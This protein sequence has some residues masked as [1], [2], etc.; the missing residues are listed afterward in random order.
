[1]FDKSTAFVFTVLVISAQGFSVSGAKERRSLG[2]NSKDATGTGIFGADSEPRLLPAPSTDGDDDV[3]YEVPHT[4]NTTEGPS[5]GGRSGTSAAY[6]GG[7]ARSRP[8]P[9]RSRTGRIRDAA[10]ERRGRGG[11]KQLLFPRD[12]LVLRQRRESENGSDSKS[13]NHDNDDN[14]D[15]QEDDGDY[16]DFEDEDGDTLH[17]QG[18][19]GMQPRPGPGRH[20]PGERAG[21]VWVIW[22]YPP[23]RR[24]GGGGSGG[25]GGGGG[26]G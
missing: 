22:V 23:R 6:G 2:D 15:D 9:E 14:N 3:E 21:C 13:D 17:K 7:R 8:L 24:G 20:Q 26:G 25:G 16:D 19:R 1:M 12:S 18:R 11:S 5:S 10:E 4:V